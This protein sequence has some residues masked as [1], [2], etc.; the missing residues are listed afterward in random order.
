M[1][2]AGVYLF[3]S[4]GIC[5]LQYWLMFLETPNPTTF[6]FVFQI[7]EKIFIEKNKFKRRAFGFWNFFSDKDEFNF[8]Q[9]EDGCF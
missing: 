7:L 2:S 3:A 1:L 5:L 9:C 6:T 8:S 4:Y